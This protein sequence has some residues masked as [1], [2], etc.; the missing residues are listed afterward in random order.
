[1]TDRQ[2]QLAVA[3]LAGVTAVNAVGGAVYGL[4]GRASVL[5]GVVLSGW[6]AAR[7]AIIGLPSPLQPGMAAVAA[8]LMGLGARLS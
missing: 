7:V 5:A 3:G 6:I 8:G 2:A 4:S 1:V